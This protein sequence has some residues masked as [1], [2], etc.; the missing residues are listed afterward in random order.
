MP[1]GPREEKRPTDDIGR[2]VMIGKVAT[3]QIV[4]KRD[5]VSGAAA[6]FGQ[7]AAKLLREGF[8]SL[9]TP[10]SPRKQRLLDGERKSRCQSI[11][12][13]ATARF[14]HFDKIECGRVVE[15]RAR[16]IRGRSRRGDVH[17][18]RLGG[19]VEA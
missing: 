5:H 7:A 8:L 15:A 11:P 12:V 6:A 1:K 19:S 2:A 16:P 14:S 4:D 9:I 3:G 10:K 18:A 13:S 17:H